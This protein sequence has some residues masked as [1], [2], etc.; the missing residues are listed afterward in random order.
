M[1]WEPYQAGKGSPF[2]W[3]PDLCLLFLPESSLASLILTSFPHFTHSS[4]SWQAPDFPPKYRKASRKEKT[5]MLS[6]LEEILLA[7]LLHLSD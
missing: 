6:E 7:K 4:L 5:R 2:L 1:P 3:T